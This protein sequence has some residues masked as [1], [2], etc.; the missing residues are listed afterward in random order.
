M[1]TKKTKK[2][3]LLNLSEELD[4][5]HLAE[6]L[7]EVLEEGLEPDSL[8]NH[9]KEMH[10]TLQQKGHSLNASL[11]TA[12]DGEAMT[13]FSFLMNQDREYEM[14]TVETRKEILSYFK[15]IG[16][17]P[18]TADVEGWSPL[19]FLAKDHQLDLLEDCFKL[20]PECIKHINKV[21]SN[22]GG[23]HSMLSLALSESGETEEIVRLLIKNGANVHHKD[24]RKQSLLSVCAQRF[25]SENSMGGVRRKELE[26]DQLNTLKA[27]V[28]A[29]ALAP[30]VKGSKTSQSADKKVVA[31]MDIKDRALL[32]AAFNLG[33]EDSG[34]SIISYLLELGANINAKHPSTGLSVLQAAA[35]R[36]STF[37]LQKMLEHGAEINQKDHR[38]QTA[39]AEAFRL[40][41]PAS[42]RLLI[43]KGADPLV[44]DTNGMTA[45]HWA[46]IHGSH[47]A[48]I[49][50]THSLIEHVHWLCDF[51]S[52]LIGSPENKISPWLLA[53]REAPTAV[54]KA[55]WQKAQ[56]L[57]LK[58]ES[59]YKD[60]YGSDAFMFAARRGQEEIIDFLLNCYKPKPRLNHGRQDVVIH[61]VQSGVLSIVEKLWP[62][63]ASDSHADQEGNTALH[64]AV[65]H[66]N[67]ELTEFL[68]VHGVD[69]NA[70]NNNKKTALNIAMERDC[71]K[72]IVT[73]MK[74]GAT[75]DIKKVQKMSN[76]LNCKKIVLELH[77]SLQEK[78][79]L[80]ALLN[81]GSKSQQ[82]KPPSVKESLKKGPKSL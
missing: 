52:P 21:T 59:D 1:T 41:N 33:V 49:Q 82:G 16:G 73:L 9:L 4:V 5:L 54:I 14:L 12:E 38:G 17:D 6:D 50:E 39:L 79:E 74:H 58:I 40:N 71:E 53:C 57:G 76:A 31:E 30:Q 80:S 3:P 7:V 70:K 22:D 19:H 72:T 32:G 81:T 8:I 78:K 20:W 65:T 67:M 77:L 68:L 13:L 56:E 55:L 64:Y 23:K 35:H 45:L 28:E 75:V 63:R 61:A 62:Y 11:I 36:G 43:E 48:A 29:G 2:I 60:E 10:E 24:S 26:L 18:Y 69:V 66:N 27:L 34:W 44:T 37:N 51:I 42:V 47:P 15:S 25:I 46:I